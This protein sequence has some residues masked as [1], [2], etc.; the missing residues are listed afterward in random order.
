VIIAGTSVV[1]KGGRE[2]LGR[3]QLWMERLEVEWVLVRGGRG[4]GRRRDGGWDAARSGEAPVCCA[5]RLD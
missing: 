1:G 4:V 3:E 5:A 2:Q